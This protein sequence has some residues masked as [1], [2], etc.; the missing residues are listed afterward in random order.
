MK[1]IAA[2]ILCVG[3]LGVTAYFGH[4]GIDDLQEAETLGQTICSVAVIGYGV[5]AAIAL[6]GLLLRKRWAVWA[7]GAW[8]LCLLVSGTLAQR[9][10]APEVPLQ[11]WVTPLTTLVILA[12]GLGVMRL[13]RY[14]TAST[15]AATSRT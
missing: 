12:I 15:R 5:T 3:L 11:W 1:R 4:E 2:W 13:V 7:A 9:V 10:W 8:T 6:V 14:L